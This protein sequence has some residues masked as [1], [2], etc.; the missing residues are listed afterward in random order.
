M[1]RSAALVAGVIL[2]CIVG[3]AIASAKPSKQA[4]AV[5]AVK[6]A[7]QEKYPQFNTIPSYLNV[8]GTHVA[9]TCHQLS[10]SKLKCTWR[11]NNDL[12][13]HAWGGARVT[14]YPHGGDARLFNVHCEKPYGHC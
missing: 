3:A 2:L 7:V 6:E 8:D 4:T 13:E 10:S 12:H 9:V 5:R 1:K 11:A 14:I